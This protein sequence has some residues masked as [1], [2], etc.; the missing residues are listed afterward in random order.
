MRPLESIAAQQEAPRSFFSG[1]RGNRA[2]AGG[3]ELIFADARRRESA[4]VSNAAERANRTP[5]RAPR[6]EAPERNRNERRDDAQTQ[7]ASQ[8][9]EAVPVNE[10]DN[11]H[12]TQAEYATQ[13]TESA[14]APTEVTYETAPIDQIPDED[15][16]AA[17]AEILQISPEALL[18]MLEQLDMPVKDLAEPKAVAAL[19]QM[20]YEAESPAALLSEPEFPANYKA[21]NEAM[22]QMAETGESKPAVQTYTATQTAL[23]ANAETQ[24]ANTARVTVTEGLTYTTENG[25]LVITDADAEEEIDLLAQRATAQ[26][27]SASQTGAQTAST[28]AASAVQPA[29]VDDTT[30]APVEEMPVDTTAVNVQ[31]LTSMVADRMQ[32]VQVTQQ[33][34]TA[35]HVNPT[36]VINQ[37]M[38]QI[39]VHTGE[40]V[41]EMRMTLRPESLGDIVLRVMTQNGIVT[42]QFIAENQRVREALESS[43]NQ[44]RDALREQG[45]QFSELSVSVKQDGEDPQQL[46][47]QGRQSTRNRAQ[48][49]NAAL[50]EDGSVP[51]AQN[52]DFDNTTINLTA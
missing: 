9:N 39:R 41:T 52:I 16:L 29:A 21:I 32:A 3:F 19:L 14:E 10:N 11:T 2:N 48:N 46:F 45:I 8:P 33:A 20:V 12:Y 4:Q 37:I 49:I 7:Q 25:E 43:F 1:E 26:A 50:E 23:N 24:A 40:Q 15:I 28:Q 38:S 27:Q 18:A 22:K 35:Q 44:L 30:L 42:A 31:P 17:I 36:D 51:E 6:A 34:Q 13:Y 47:E 5:D